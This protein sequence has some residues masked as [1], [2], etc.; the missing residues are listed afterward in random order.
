MKHPYWMEERWSS[1]LHKIKNKRPRV[2]TVIIPDYTHTLTRSGFLALFC[3]RLFSQRCL[4]LR[5]SLSLPVYL[6]S[7]ALANLHPANLC[8]A[9]WRARAGGGGGRWRSRGI[10]LNT[11]CVSLRRGSNVIELFFYPLNA[12]WNPL[13][14]QRV[15]EW[16]HRTRV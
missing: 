10:Q 15:S 7:S 9:Q 13:I 2:P 11:A 3:F 8:E 1:D 6:A 4:C 5:W 12:Q 16:N 14:T